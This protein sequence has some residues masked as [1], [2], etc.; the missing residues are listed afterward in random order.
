MNLTSALA[1]VA[2]LACLAPGCGGD[3]PASSDPGP[4]SDVA[5]GQGQGSGLYT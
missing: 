5:L 2:W 1:L 4:W 3:G